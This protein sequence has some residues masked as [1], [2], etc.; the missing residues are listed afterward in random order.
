MVKL[1]KFR[2]SAVY[3]DIKV[4]F[5]I[6]NLFDLHYTH[7]S[8]ISHNKRKYK[9]KLWLKKKKQVD[10]GRVKGEAI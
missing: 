2:R 1:T 5:G 8:R 4:P 9:R 3:F 6:K 7:V 10:W